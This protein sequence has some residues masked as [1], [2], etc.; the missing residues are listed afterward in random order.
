M[1][2]LWPKRN[3]QDAITSLRER[4]YGRRVGCND[5]IALVPSLSSSIKPLL[6]CTLALVLLGGRDGPSASVGLDLGDATCA[7]GCRGGALDILPVVRCRGAGNPPFGPSLDT[8]C[9]T[10]GCAA[11]TVLSVP[12]SLLSWLSRRS[13]DLV[14][15]A[16]FFG[17]GGTGLR[18][19]ID[20]FDA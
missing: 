18:D 5:G 9:I 20:I 6:L 14:S 4:F 17:T 3:S 16:G 8:L 15:R 12:A 1:I 19:D 7:G 11:D 2:C 10:G 13:L